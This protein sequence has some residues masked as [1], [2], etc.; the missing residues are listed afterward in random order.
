MLTLAVIGAAH[1]ALSGDIQCGKSHNTETNPP[2]KTETANDYFEMGD[3]QYDLGSCDEAINN[4][5]NAINMDSNFAEA[6]N[7]RGYTYM[8]LREYDKALKDLDKAI[9]IR[10]DYVHA[11]MN[12]G[13]IYNYYY[14]I[15]RQ[16][17][18]EDYNKVLDLVKDKNARRDLAVCGHKLIAENG[19]WS[20][21]IY[22]ELVKNGI[23]NAGCE[24]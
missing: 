19:G 6:L 23:T 16:K 8:R 2:A 13:D 17:A 3:Y 20:P 4:Y 22:L 11:L 10:P 1:S 7:N 5:T 15:D 21:V 18:I 14:E 24:K 9:E 12:R